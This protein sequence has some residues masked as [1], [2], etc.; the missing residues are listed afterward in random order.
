MINKFLCNKKTQI[1]SLR[2]SV[3]TRGFHPRK[4]GSIPLGTANI[5]FYVYLIVTKTNNKLISY[6]GF[7]NNLKKRLYLHNQSKGAKFTKGRS[8]KLIYFNK[9][10]S[11]IKALKE[12]YKLKK[13][14]KLR[15]IIKRNYYKNEN[16][17]FITL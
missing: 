4:R 9:Y 8:W 13:N 17:N 7:T 16:I 3:R 10:K 1:R 11:K 5:M 12:E 14:Y 2:L 6:V 15:A